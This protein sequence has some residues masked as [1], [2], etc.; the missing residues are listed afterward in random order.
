MTSVVKGAE[1]LH[2]FSLCGRGRV[3]EEAG[4]LMTTVD[5]ADIRGLGTT[6]VFPSSACLGLESRV[7]RSRLVTLSRVAPFRGRAPSPT[8]PWCEPIWSRG[9]GDLL[10]DGPHEGGELAG[11]GGDADV[12]MLAACDETAEAFAETDLGLPGDVLDRLGQ[13]LETFADVRGDLGGVLVGPGTLDENATGVTMTGFGDGAL[14][15]GLAGR[16]LAG[17]ET[18]EAG[19]LAWVV[20]AGEVAD[21]GEHGDG[22]GVLD[23]AQGLEGANDGGEPPGGNQIGE[24]GLDALEALDL[25]ADGTQRLLE[26]DLLRRC[27]ADDLGEVAEMGVVPVGAAGV[28]EAETEEEGLQPELGGLEGDDGGLAGATEIAQR[29]VLDGGDVDGVEV[30]GAQQA[31]ELDGIAAVGLDAVAGLFRDERRG[32][33]QA[34]DAAAREVA[35]QNVAAGAGLIGD[36]EAVGLLLEPANEP[37]DVGRARADAADVGDV[38]AAVVRDVGHRDG[39]LVHIE[40]DK[41]RGGLLH[42]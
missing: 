25:L 31:G 27:G 4:P 41:Q 7:G 14:A 40:T 34:G 3:R 35:I 24:L 11:D 19:E 36:H 18:E 6:L 39:L 15:A 23:A 22:D 26:D 2:G 9:D 37:V 17:D 30:T 1:G 42:G 29:F 20:E 12:G 38:G 21:F 10:G 8:L 32:D 13:A 28:V 5:P 16:V 33:D